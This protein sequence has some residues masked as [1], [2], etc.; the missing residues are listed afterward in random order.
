MIGEEY[1]ED[2]LMMLST[3]IKVIKEIDAENE[4][5]KS[6]LDA[7]TLEVVHLNTEIEHIQIKQ[8]QITRV[9]SERTK[10][11]EKNVSTIFNN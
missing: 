6:K 11:I 1:A 5:V 4:L 7:K 9:L 8:D 3:S 2:F 10:E